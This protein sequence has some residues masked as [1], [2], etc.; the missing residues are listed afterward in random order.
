V[1]QIDLLPDDVLLEIF[2]F[3][4]GINLLFKGKPL[5]KPDI[6]AW[7]S[8]VHVCR[9]WR[10]LVLGSPRCLN[11]QLYCTPKT[12]AKD[13]LDV[14]PALPLLIEGDMKTTPGVDNIAAALGRSNCVSEVLLWGLAWQLEEVLA[15][16]QVPF[17]E[18][19]D[20][21]LF[22]YHDET[23]PVIPDSFLGGSAPRL[24]ILMLDSISFPGLPKL[25]PSATRLVH[26]DVCNIPHSGY[27]SPEAM[28][29][30]ISV[31]SSLNSLALGFRSP[32]SRPDWESR[33]LPPPKRSILPALHEFRFTGVTEY[34]ED[35]VAFI[36]AP[37]LDHMNITFFNQIDFYSPRLIQFIN[38][39]PTLRAFD[40]AR[41][42][43]NDYTASVIHLYRT[44]EMDG[45]L[46]ISISCREPDWQLSSIEQVC[47]SSLPPLP[48]V[49]DLY[50]EHDYS[51]QVWKN[52]AIENDLWLQLL[53][54]FT[55]VKNLHLPKEFAPGIAGA[56]Q[57]L[58]GGRITEVLPSLQNIFVEEPEA[59]GPFQEK[60]G[61]F[62]TA[63]QLSG[64]PV[65]ISVKPVRNEGEEEQEPCMHSTLASIG[66]EAD[67]VAYTQRRNYGRT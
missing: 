43:F 26:L 45:F 30:L 24:R 22:S 35:L 8:L 1:K 12:P 19:T 7:Q 42:G 44:Y 23:T 32:Q 46:W 60:I 14:W 65:T 21:R 18:L 16:M 10:N 61:Q 67:I 15:P 13:T 53:L 17:P 52:D 51:Q 50:I 25:I 66:R 41:V 9:R 59:L 6:E 58:V 48:M 57:D 64:R 40:K 20:L 31:L 39:T 11:L 37:Q 5:G 3:Y 2:D 4:K 28:V 38:C 56:L 29:A 49:E 54:P 47:N 36:D 55:V 34:L 62:V 63:R 33:S 27:I